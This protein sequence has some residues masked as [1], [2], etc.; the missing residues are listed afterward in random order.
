MVRADT[1]NLDFHVH[2]LADGRGT[3]PPAG[4]QLPSAAVQG[5]SQAGASRTALEQA[6][7]V[8]RGGR[9]SASG[10]FAGVK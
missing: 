9:G 4:H 6:A 7:A 2:V 5:D 3:A 1:S 10:A 8:R